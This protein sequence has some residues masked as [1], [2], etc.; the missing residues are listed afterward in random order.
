MV[1]DA[2]GHGMAA[3]LVMAIADAT[4]ATAMD[5]DPAPMRVLDLLNR[6]LCRTGDRRTFMSLFYA[7]LDAG[8]RRLEYVCAGHPFPVL[9]RAGGEVVEL[10]CGALPLGLKGTVEYE[11]GEVTLG[12]GDALLL[13]TDGLVEATNGAGEAFGFERLRRIVATGGTAQAIQDRVRTAFDEHLGDEPLRDDLTLV[14]M[15]RL[16]LGPPP[17]PP[18]PP[19]P[20]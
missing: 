2:S 17:P 13:F 12:P 1:G 6:T 4:L 20:S 16:P 3:G 10:G 11:P 9:R 14:A 18:P 19:T 8:D 15:A 5:L 7:L